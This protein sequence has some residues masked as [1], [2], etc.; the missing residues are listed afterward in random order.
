M[1]LFL[2]TAVSVAVPGPT[3]GQQEESAEES[4]EEKEGQNPDR[5]DQVDILRTRAVAAIRAGE[6]GR[7]LELL[8]RVGEGQDDRDKRKLASLRAAARQGRGE[9]R[10]FEGDIEGAIADFDAF[11]SSHPEREPHH[12][13]RGIAYYYLEEYEKGAAQFERHQVVNS[14]DVENA[15]WHFLC[16]A[17]AP[18][19]SFEAAREALIP[20]EG[21]SR[22]PMREVHDLFAG[23]GSVE[24]VL[25]AAEAEPGEDPEGVLLRNQLCY[26]HLYLALYFEAKGEDEKSREHIRLAA[27]DYRMNHYMGRVAQLHAKLR[28]VVES[29]EREE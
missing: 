16:T 14:S 9:E 27:E 15:V 24:E 20:I 7:A 12:W 28:G 4:P 25:E 6:Y 19:G 11:L 5:A 23:G 29:E 21:D 26:A 1:T 10:F 8:D 3:F 22:V 2:W 17:R 13:Q 18:G